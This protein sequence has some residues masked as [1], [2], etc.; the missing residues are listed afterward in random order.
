MDIS[1]LNKIEVSSKVFCDIV[2]IK[3]SNYLSELV[4]D[5]GFIRSAHGKYPLLQNF[6]RFISYQDELHDIDIKK[7]REG[8][9]KSRLDNAQAELKE[10]ELKEKQN[11]LGPIAEFELAHKN[12]A[13]LFKKAIEGLRS[14]FKFDLNLNEDQSNEMDKQFNGVLTQL[15]NLPADTNAESITL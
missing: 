4:K 13:L 6:K 12:Q 1:E 3:N 7:I 15:A 10:L 9:S 8:N 2:G 5:H 11:Q 14:R